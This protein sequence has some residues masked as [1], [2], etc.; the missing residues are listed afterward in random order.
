MGNFDT[1]VDG[2]S[3]ECTLRGDEIDDCLPFGK[4]DDVEPDE[5]MDSILDGDDLPF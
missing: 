5:D 1:V 4:V 3:D 2:F